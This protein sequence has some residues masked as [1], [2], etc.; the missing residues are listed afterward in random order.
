MNPFDH[1]WS[2]LKEVGSF[3]S[4]DPDD[5]YSVNPYAEM[6]GILGGNRDYEAES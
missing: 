1:A 3:N 5:K 4:I 6:M 2:V